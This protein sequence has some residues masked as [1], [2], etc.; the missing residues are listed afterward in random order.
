MKQPET[1]KASVSI[2][3]ESM[4]ALVRALTRIADEGMTI[5]QSAAVSTTIS[6]ES[7]DIDDLDFALRCI[8]KALGKSDDVTAKISAPATIWDGRRLDPTPMERAI[9]AAGGLF[10]ED[11]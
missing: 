3:A 5:I 9:N 4:P 1:I 2:K 8:A 11:V 10:E 7:G 6:L